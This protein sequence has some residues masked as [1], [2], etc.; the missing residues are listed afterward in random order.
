MQKRKQFKGSLKTD[1]K[2]CGKE[3][4]PGKCPAYTCGCGTCGRRNHFSVPWRSKN[5][6]N[7]TEN[8]YELDN[9]SKFNYSDDIN[10]FLGNCQ[11]NTDRTCQV[12]INIEQ[13]KS[14]VFCV[15]TGADVSLINRDTYERLNYNPGFIKNK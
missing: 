7:S 4:A 12:P 6:I 8:S 14:I 3:H 5:D 13:V 9:E 1:F 15:D 11:G 2:F 10:I